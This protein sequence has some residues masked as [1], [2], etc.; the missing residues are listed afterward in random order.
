MREDCCHYESRTYDDGEV[1]RFCTKDLAPEAPWRCPNP[2]VGYERIMMIRSDFEAGTLANAPKVEDEPE[3]EVADIVDVLADAE[4]IV[5]AAAPDV[6]AEL[7][8]PPRPRFSWWRRR[9]GGDDGDDF[10]LSSR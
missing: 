7:D 6:V 5:A 8:R 2:C 9:K 10:G 3:G 4:A 1:A